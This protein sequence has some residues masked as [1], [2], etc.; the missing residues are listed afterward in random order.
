VN[1]R[2]LNYDAR[3]LSCDDPIERTDRAFVERG[4]GAW[5]EYCDPP[6]NLRLY[7]RERDARVAHRPPRFDPFDD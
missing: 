1:P 6:R 2:R 5:H 4:V 7:Q 3:C